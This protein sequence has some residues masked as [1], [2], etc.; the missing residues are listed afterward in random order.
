M[1]SLKLNSF[2]EIINALKNP[3]VTKTTCEELKKLPNLQ[4][5]SSLKDSMAILTV[6]SDHQNWHP[7][8]T[9]LQT[10]KD[11]CKKIQNGLLRPILDELVQGRKN[12]VMKI[13]MLGRKKFKPNSYQS[14]GS[15]TSPCLTKASM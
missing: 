4:N 12:S 3:E 1:T 6:I 15:L 14:G 7:F 5:F 10:L 8:E 2:S 11:A 13:L 9:S